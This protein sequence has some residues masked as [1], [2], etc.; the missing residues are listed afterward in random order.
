MTKKI[1]KPRRYSVRPDWSYKGIIV[2]ATG[3][4]DALNQAPHM[5]DKQLIPFTHSCGL[6]SQ[7]FEWGV[8]YERA[9]VFVDVVRL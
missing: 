9:Q 1:R 5:W 7:R 4:W 8:R 3:P 6:A 2:L